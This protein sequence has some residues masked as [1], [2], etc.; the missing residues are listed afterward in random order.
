[1]P[2]SSRHDRGFDPM[3]STFRPSAILVRHAAAMRAQ[4]PTHRE[5]RVG[6]PAC[7][8]ATKGRELSIRFSPARA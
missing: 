5:P 3:M 2:P 7:L 4:H 6:C 1:M 8:A